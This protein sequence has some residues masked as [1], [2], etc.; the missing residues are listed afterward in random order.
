MNNLIRVTQVSWNNFETK[1]KV[2]MKEIKKKEE[3]NIKK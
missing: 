3:G 1:K 2:R